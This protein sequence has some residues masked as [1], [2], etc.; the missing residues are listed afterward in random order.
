VL[1]NH[2]GQGGTTIL[3][4]FQELLT[5]SAADKTA[6]GPFNYAVT[7][8]MARTSGDYSSSTANP[9]QASDASKFGS[10]AINFATAGA[11]LASIYAFKF[12]VTLSSGNGV[13]KNGIHW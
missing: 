2:T 6:Q 13:T 11:D 3:S 1:S 7:E 12:S 10:Q 4:N 5:A 9:D 8:F